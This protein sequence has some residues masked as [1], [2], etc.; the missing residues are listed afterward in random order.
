MFTDKKPKA[1]AIVGNQQNRITEGTTITGDLI[2]KSGMRIDGN[3]KGNVKTPS[4][5]VLGEKGVIKG[6]LECENADLEGSFSGNMTIS[7]T[8]TLRATARVD[9]DV[10]AGKLAIEPGAAFNAT[11]VMKGSV[12]QMVEKETKTEEDLKSQ[13]HL[14]EKQERNSKPKTEQS[15]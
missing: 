13:N 3:V 12:K 15:V 10:V 7:G 6:T 14:F 1:P 8:L 5:V 4:K 11:C 2:S 9:G